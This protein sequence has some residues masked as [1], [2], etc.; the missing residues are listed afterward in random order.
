MGTKQIA[1]AKL[2]RPRLHDVLA[3]TRLHALLDKAGRRPVIWLCAH[4]GAGKTTLV[5]SYAQARKRP[6]IWYQLDAADADPASFVYHLRL[7]ADAADEADALPLLTPEYQ[8]DLPGFAR[9]FFRALFA[10]LGP[11]A[12]L[13]LDNFQ[14]VPEDAAFHRVVSEAMAQVP[15]GINVIVASRVEPPSA[16][17]PL[18]ADDAIALVE[19]D[20]LQLT[21]AETQA[22]ADKRGVR[23]EAAVHALHERSHG[24]AAGLTLLLVR[25]R[26]SPV[27]PEDGDPEPLQHVFGYFAQR[28]FDD[29]PPAHRRALMH[30]SFAP[31]FDADLALALT[32]AEDVARLLEQLYRRRLFIERRRLMAAALGAN[33]ISLGSFH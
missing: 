16:Y 23:D 10:R 17:A 1:L 32:G 2:S 26:R 18:L 20:E 28:V 24:W 4:P 15:E 14:D 9:R 27:R 3:R 13:V 7:A 33:H 31:V 6:G 5:A 21:L 25:A 11:G 22:I 30:L 12:L 29:T 19:G 8:Q